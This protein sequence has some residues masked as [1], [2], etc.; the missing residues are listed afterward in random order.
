MAVA[1]EIA[2]Y[3]LL[4]PSKLSSFFYYAGV[5]IYHTAIRIPAL[6]VEYAFGGS[7]SL[8]TGQSN[9]SGIFSLPS[10]EDASAVERMMP[11][12]RF[13]KRIPVGTA[14]PR[15]GRVREDSES[16]SEFGLLRHKW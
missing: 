8:D 16:Y 6:G 10:P 9:V 7:L 1:V 2:V 15:A 5:G 3:D 11:G 13:V 14:K 12:L 4:P